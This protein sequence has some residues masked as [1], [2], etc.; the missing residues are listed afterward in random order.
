MTNQDHL[1]YVPLTN[2]PGVFAVVDESDFALVSQYRWYAQDSKPGYTYARAHSAECI[3][4]HRLLLNLTHRHQMGDHK[5]GNGLDNR[6]ANL[7]SASRPQ[8]LANS[9]KRRIRTTHYAPLQRSPF[10]GVRF[11]RDRKQFTAQIVVNHK[12]I[13]LGYFNQDDEAAAKA[14][15]EAARRYY[16]EFAWTNF[17][18]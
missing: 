2:R 14:Y 11:R 10:K 8:N 9:R 13:H 4:M 15:D 1:Y 17:P 7:R 5:N 16:G 18:K 12:F 6:R 3:L